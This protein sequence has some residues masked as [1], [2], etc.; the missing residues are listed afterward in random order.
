MPPVS[1][2]AI[3]IPF[4]GNSQ[5][6]EETL[7]SV[8]ENRPDDCE[9]IVV[10]GIIADRFSLETTFYTAAA[11]MAAGVAVFAWKLRRSCEKSQSADPAQYRR[12]L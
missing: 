8:L 4:L 10:L 9:V 1:R 5:R 12:S 2:L 7:V 3:I 6:L 11:C